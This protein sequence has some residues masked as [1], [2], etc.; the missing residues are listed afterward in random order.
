MEPAPPLS[1]GPSLLR[2]SNNATRH[3]TTSSSK[4]RR[5]LQDKPVPK[6][7]NYR[8]RVSLKTLNCVESIE[9]QE[10]WYENSLDSDSDSDSDPDSGSDSDSGSGSDSDQD[11]KPEQVFDDSSETDTGRSRPRKIQLDVHA[12]VK[13]KRSTRVTAPHKLVD[14]SSESDDGATPDV[15]WKRNRRGIVSPPTPCP[16]D[17]GVKRPGRPHTHG[18]S[19][20]LEP[21]HVHYKFNRFLSYEL[22]R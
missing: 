9:N 17:G 7:L 3:P 16:N 6:R 21:G 11:F 20:L 15:L 8:R 12:D 19:K 10:Y 13:I 22:P 18:P 2:T 4:C 14:W 1:A 5:S